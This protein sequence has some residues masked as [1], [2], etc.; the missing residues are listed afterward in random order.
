MPSS[1][2]AGDAHIFKELRRTNADYCFRFSILYH[3][4]AP[5]AVLPP[6]SRA[7]PLVRQ[8]NL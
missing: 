2:W 5:L 4:R 1:L 8:I 6:L 7:L 3:D